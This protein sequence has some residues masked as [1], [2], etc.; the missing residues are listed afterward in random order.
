MR[1]GVSNT[2]NLTNELTSTQEM[3]LRRFAA[4]I[5]SLVAAVLLAGAAPAQSSAEASPWEVTNVKLMLLDET[6]ATV[7]W[8]VV[9]HPDRVSPAGLEVKVTGRDDQWLPGT[10]GRIELT[11]LAYDT[12]YTVE[13]RSRTAQGT[14]SEPGS[15]TFR[16]LPVNR[17]PSAPENVTVTETSGCYAR[18]T[19]DRSIDPDGGWIGYQVTYDGRTVSFPSR[20]D[21][22]AAYVLFDLARETD[23]TAEL[24]AID[25]RGGLSEP[26]AFSFRTAEFCQDDPPTATGPVTV[27]DVKLTSATLTFDPARGFPTD[28]LQYYA[29]DESLPRGAQDLAYAPRSGPLKLINLTPNTTYRLTVRATAGRSDFG[30]GQPVTFTTPA[31]ERQYAWTGSFGATK[32]FPTGPKISGT[33]EFD[34][35]TLTNFTINPV[36]ARLRQ[37]G[38]IPLTADVAFISSAEPT[39]GFEGHRVRMRW[40]GKVR[41]VRAYLFGAV[42]ISGL[43]TCQSKRVATLES[44]AGVGATSYFNFE[45]GDFS[46]CGAL[47]GLF[48]PLVGA[49]PWH[50]QFHVKITPSGS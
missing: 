14:F 50:D 49:P 12:E 20:V 30:P 39:G 29:L 19:W 43:G 9:S 28:Y 10:P 38:T 15:V 11:D 18:F 34:G 40:R 41:I 13:V 16:T 48:S 5:L 46:G 23:Y 3:R 37:L 8:Q 21:R 6:T 31:P 35:N 33:V 7:W 24:R 36:R 17:V 26:A 4:F 45:L 27:S 25:E 42:E 47:N 44:F 22:E 2:V 32:L 1:A